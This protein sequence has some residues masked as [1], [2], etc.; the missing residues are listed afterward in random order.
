MSGGRGDVRVPPYLGRLLA[1]DGT[2]VG[3]CFQVAPG[4]VATA[5]HVLDR[6]GAGKVGCDVAIDSLA[7][8]SDA[9]GATVRAVDELADLALLETSRPLEA[10]VVGFRATDGEPIG[11]KVVVTGVS[12]VADP[13]HD[14][15]FLDAPGE[16]A[17]GTTRDDQVPLGRMLAGDI[18]PGMSGA[19]VRGREDDVV[20]GLVSGRYN[21]TD[22]WLSGTVWVARS[23]QL[24]ALC[25][26]IAE[27]EVRGSAPT[28][29]LA[30]TL[31]VDRS[32]VHLH[33][34]GVDERISHAGVRP[35]LVEAIDEVRRG[36]S[37]NSS[38][39][40]PDPSAEASIGD[41]L[42]RTGE[43]LAESFLS[44]PV[45]EALTDVLE[46]AEGAHQAVHIGVSCPDE[47]SRLP[48]EALLDPRTDAPL[49]LNPLVRLFR[50]LPDANAAKIPGPLRIL[51]AISSPDDGDGP[52][53]EYERE[54][55]MVLSA[56][57][58]ARQSEAHVRIV[59]FATT[60]A[61]REALEREP[62]HILHFSGH[63]R[64]GQLVFEDDEGSA[65]PLDPDTF[66]GEAIPPG[67]MPP[68][69]ALSACH[70]NVGTTNGVP[71]FAAR[72]VQRGA[73]V[74]LATETSLT[75]VYA[76]RVFAR[77]YGRLAETA[78]PDIVGAACDARRMVQAEL[79]SAARKREQQV[80]ELDEWAV[81]SIT[82]AR[83]SVLVFDPAVR[84]PVSPPAPRFTIG[85]VA[86]R[87]T[88]DFV[89]RR[90]EQRR[91]PI[92]L[93]AENVAG[94]V[95]H[96]IGGVGKTTLAAELVS[97]VAERE[98]ARA[99]L[100]IAGA[101]T[102]DGLLSEMVGVLK[103]NALLTDGLP[104]AVVGALNAAGRSDV[105]WNDRLALLRE[106]VFGVLPLLA[107]LDNFE[108]NL[109]RDERPAT[110]R[111]P[112]L[113]E[114]L[115]TWIEAPGSSRLLI[116]CR[117]P[118]SLPRSAE[119][120]LEFKP[121]G[122]LS[123]AETGKLLWSLPS[124]D[125]LTAPEVERVWRLVGGHPRSLEY[126]DALLQKGSGRYPDITTRLEKAVTDRLGPDKA[127]RLLGTNRTLDQAIAEVATL[128]ADDVLLGQLVAELKGVP[129]AGDLLLGLSTFREP[130]DLNGAL[131]QVGEADESAARE[132]RYKEASQKI[133]EGLEA[134]GID[135]SG[136]ID[137]EAL[138]AEV[139]EELAPHVDVMRTLP[140]P[141]LAPPAGMER[142]IDAAV[143]ASLLT[144]IAEQG[145]RRLFVHRWTAGELHR[146]AE[147]EGGASKLAAAHRKAAEYWRWRVAIWPQKLRPDVH[148][149]IEARHHY[150]EAGDLESAS[151]ITEAICLQLEQWGAWDDEAMLIRDILRRQPPASDLAGIWLG[152]L[153]NVLFR[154]GDLAEAERLYLQAQEILERLGDQAGIKAGLHQLGL[155]A[156]VQGDIEKAE[157]LFKKSLEIAK[158][159]NDRTGLAATYGQLGMLSHLRGDLNNA[160]RLFRT[161]LKLKEEL[162]DRSAIATSLHQLG[163][164]EQDRGNAKEAEDLYEKSLELD[165]KLE[166]PQG[167][168]R[169]YHQLGQ[170]EESRGNLAAADR[171]YRE[172][173]EIKERLGDLRG[174]GATTHQLGI[175][176]EEKGDHETAERLY[177]RALAINEQ[178][179]DVSAMASGYGQSGILAEA[180]NELDKASD[181]Y[182]KTLAIHESLGH[183]PGVVRT[184]RRL[185]LLAWKR[186]DLEEAKSRYARAL[187]I[188]EELDSREDVIRST[189][190]LATVAQREG[191]VED[192]ESLY[193]QVL[194]LGEQA[195][196]SMT[197]A[198]ATSQLGSLRR[199]QG[200]VEESIAL[201]AKALAIRLA[202][203]SDTTAFDVRRLQDHAESA[204]E[205][206]VEAVVNEALSEAEAAKVLAALRE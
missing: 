205:G 160:E 177:D 78:T 5:W 66:V 28:S 129:G 174:I 189:Y 15:R 199:D 30:L 51:V 82:A 193:G 206:T 131:F 97:R 140:S 6:I 14:Y 19:P 77:I 143:E 204:G 4:F 110:V 195:D 16:W 80:A 163:T 115:A 150:L 65:R 134:A 85:S 73:S 21:S 167:I 126:L 142:M 196:D 71:S 201:H 49:A 113:A 96:G 118:F 182:L 70:S 132:P 144:E 42:A 162:P 72:L 172:S 202:T 95:L 81:L 119:A 168:A 44:G 194:A 180:R 104:D 60:A 139:A 17:G 128:A 112:I 192:A 179:G 178:L 2:P 11:R 159:T 181:L 34:A 24:E 200:E 43:L 41:A 61:I 46:R 109:S 37:H 55:K 151:D 158:S 157:G 155:I 50:L 35:A 84:E 124:L 83:G 76:T 171:Y 125:R 133:N 173:L 169:T 170:L 40:P 29:S 99:C 102:V 156:Q 164:L 31:A 48:W 197:V 10:S 56:V 93:L 111:D 53:L 100:V 122:P 130:V 26:G 107:V 12:D 146:R 188:S 114:L 67:A 7:V 198:M 136:P 152:Q 23:E 141:P 94:L 27:F 185:G 98:P 149:L 47:L 52:L 20:V 138:P 9:R 18:V 117:Y 3:T 22:G 161:S 54:L 64:P 175:L 87:S 62:A 59:P 86:A 116:T 147:E 91:W 105:S 153:G 79:R 166:N 184:L 137:L 123:G 58:A 39:R 57:R 89:G 74:V 13:G 108:D 106:H 135:Q 127:A 88:G 121:V 148:D 120:K 1:P 32:E 203:A 25:S 75:D 69:V 33:G 90:R 36:R 92:E 63:G 183:R 101:T 165:R 176:A 38:N 190:L 145:D 8:G 103:R 191:A 45:S 186:N 68:V 154:K 187:E